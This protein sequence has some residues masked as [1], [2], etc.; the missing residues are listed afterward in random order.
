MAEI[1][2]T[3]HSCGESAVSVAAKLGDREVQATVPGLVVELVSSGESGEHGHTFRFVPEGEEHMAEL[4]ALFGIGNVVKATFNLV[5]AAE[6]A[7]EPEA[8]DAA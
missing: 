4:K 8:R 7:A 5:A 3:V 6:P 2:Y 1:E